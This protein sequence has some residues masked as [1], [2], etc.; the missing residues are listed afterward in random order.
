MGGGHYEGLVA[1]DVPHGYE[2]EYGGGNREYGGN[3]GDHSGVPEFDV[4]DYE[5]CLVSD[6]D[7][8]IYVADAYLH[9]SFPIVEDG[10]NAKHC[11]DQCHDECGVDL[12]VSYD[13]RDS[14][15]P[16]YLYHGGEKHGY[17]KSGGNGQKEGLYSLYHGANILKTADISKKCLDLASKT[18]LIME[19]IGNSELIVNGDG[20]VFHLHL[21]PEHLADTVILVG[22]PGRVQMVASFFTSVESSS[23]S[24][25]FNSV[26]GVYGG[27][28]MTVLSTGIGCDNIDIVMTELDALANVDFSTRTV[29]EDRRRL[30][31]LRI[32][33]CGA[34]HADIP[35]G[36]YVFSDI[37]I[38]FDGLLNWYAGRD[39]VSD[40]DMEEALMSH[41]GWNRYLPVPYFAKASER[42]SALF[43]DSTVG[44]MT[45]S[46]SGF[47]GPQCR[48][49]RLPLA[50]PDLMEKIESFRYGGMRINNFEMEGSAIAGLARK[51]GHDAGTV[52]LAIAN[53]YVKDANPDY[54]P[55]MRS[56]VEMCLD[57]LS[58][59]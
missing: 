26:T 45:I 53:R 37:S 49:V 1:G 29:R 59:L 23:S 11:G 52:C 47:Y 24:R 13:I 4:V 3:A 18:V 14:L 33:S 6:E 22:D 5:I 19:R 58:S 16:H 10:R 7:Q 32:G 42:L 27:K 50:I 57:R 9:D 28:R 40:R 38:G 51:L 17:E 56:L 34:L 54:P 30:T 20:S 8:R 31:I 25:E 35:L 41:L 36:A 15:G 39:E 48:V 46:A 12:H 55:L 2:C 44:G 43:A 21:K